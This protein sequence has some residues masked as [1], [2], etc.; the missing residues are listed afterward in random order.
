MAKEHPL[1]ILVAEDNRINQL[2]AKKLLSK[3]GY[4]IDVAANG[5][6]A[7]QLYKMK[8]YDVIFMDCH[9]PEMDGHEATQKIIKETTYETRPR[10]IALT[11]SSLKEDRDKCRDSGM[12]DFISKPIEL[13]EIVRALKSCHQLK[14]KKSS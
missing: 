12:D 6:E 1:N 8:S 14:L 9:M 5:L 2:V 13:K 7:V 3:L 11:A 10:I 4:N